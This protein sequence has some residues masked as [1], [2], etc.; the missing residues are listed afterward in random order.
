MERKGL[1][2]FATRRLEAHEPLWAEPALLH[3][4]L[5]TE[6]EETARFCDHCLG[7]ITPP[8]IRVTGANNSKAAPSWTQLLRAQPALASQLGLSTDRA[9]RAIP[10]PCRT[11]SSTHSLHRPELPPCAESYCSVACESQAWRDRHRCEHMTPTQS[12]PLEERMEAVADMLAD[13]YKG[14]LLPLL[15]RA[16][17]ALQAEAED[18][19][20]PLHTANGTL[21]LSDHLSH[22]VVPEQV[23]HFSESELQTL[24]AALSELIAP[25]LRARPQLSRALGALDPSLT[26][27]QQLL[28]A[29]LGALSVNS[30]EVRRMQPVLHLTPAA[31]PRRSPSSTAASSPPL[32]DCA[33]DLSSPAAPSRSYATCF[34]LASFLNHA[35]EPHANVAFL[36]DEA[37]E[38]S[39][40]RLHASEPGALR[41][42]S[43]AAIR[44]VEQGEELLFC[45]GPA[46]EMPERYGFTCACLACSQAA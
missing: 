35:C 1:G 29:L 19:C 46:S 41:R 43:F 21:S 4:R 38:P 13:E 30:F 8:L 12:A 22:L 36:Q 34:S 16:L 5:E 15:L 32:F 42:W 45:Y 2:L 23:P 20:S 31:T 3:T 27:A 6:A 44:P 37:D 28:R 17:A 14:T 7:P 10:T 40:A 24:D 33:V 11:C 9:P 26:P 18:S 39:R 25:L